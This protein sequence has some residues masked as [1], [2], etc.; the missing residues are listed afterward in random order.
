[1]AAANPSQM[2]NLTTLIKRL[3]AATSRLEDLSTVVPAIELPVTSATGAP[4]APIPEP[5]PASIEEY[6]ELI[7]NEVAKYVKLSNELGESST[8]EAKERYSAIAEQS[9]SVERCFA[10]QRRFLVI[11]TKAKKPDS[12]S[13]LYMDLL[14]GM[15]TH[16]TKVSNLR[17]NNRHSPFFNHLSTVSEGIPSVIWVI[18]AKPA[19][20]VAEITAAAKYYGHRVLKE[21]KGKDQKHVDWVNS[22]YNLLAALEAYVKKHHIMGITWNAKGVDA[23]ELL[24]DPSTTPSAAPSITPSTTSGGP[25][26]PPPPPGPPPVLGVD[27]PSSPA[28]SGGDMGGVF[29][30]LNRGQ[31]VTAGLKKVDKS[32][33]THKNPELRGSSI[34]PART[35][36]SGSLRGKSPAPPSKTKPAHLTKKKPPK[37]ELDGNKWIIENYENEKNIVID[38]TEINQSVFIFR[39][40]NTTIQ[41]K[42]KVNAVS[43][44]ECTKT[45]VVAD[46]LVSCIDVIKSNS[47]AIQ[48]LQKIPTIQIDQCDG[49]T[50]Y[51]PKESLDVEIFTSKTSAVN[52]YLPPVKEED[53]YSESA[54][55]E[56]LKHSI[57]NGQLVSEIVEH[58]G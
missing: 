29:A 40:K 49:G 43:I 46:S 3:E 21:Y 31:S 10:E 41:I 11:A 32:Q 39:C 50:I 48:V 13:Q 57:K 26:P 7:V 55:P 15:Q 14:A 30:E 52:V 22:Y 12:Q 20:F 2:N 5:L 27:G 8:E 45:D 54:V 36:S 28:P 17:E 56:Q 4:A 9:K 25:P 47:F 23:R 6:D 37:T 53:D 51:I 38:N 24:I 1:M 16:C 34:V 58:A 19:K 33:M 35:P 18:D 44:N 42:G